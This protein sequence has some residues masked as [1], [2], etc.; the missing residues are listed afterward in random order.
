MNRGSGIE[1]HAKLDCHE[2]GSAT[3]T[4][5]VCLR[6]Y[7][8][9]AYDEYLGDSISHQEIAEGLCDEVEF[10]HKVVTSSASFDSEGDSLVIDMVL[11]VPEYLRDMS[12]NKL[13]TP[14]LTPIADNPFES[15]WRY[16]PIDFR[17]PRYRSR[18]TVISF[19]EGMTASEVP[20]DVNI[21]LDGWRYTRMSMTSGLE[22]IVM[23]SLSIEKAV[24]SPSEYSDLKEASDFMTEAALDELLLTSSDM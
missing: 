12:G 20:T 4:A 9:S 22:V 1:T 11:E 2:D 24:F 8:L 19:P 10:E 21:A 17:Y 14:C 5:R 15:D 7:E 13:M 18:T 16:F 6:G 23:E 3:V